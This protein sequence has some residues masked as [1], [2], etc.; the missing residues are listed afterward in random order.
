MFRIAFVLAV[1]SAAFAASG[2]RAQNGLAGSAPADS[3]DSHYTFSR[4]QDGYLRLDNRTGQVSFCNKRTVGWARQLVPE[5]RVA[6]EG[7][8][9]RLQ[10]ENATLK[11]EF[12]TRGLPLPG[13]IQGD[14]PP[15]QGERSLKPR[16]DANIERMRSLAE[17]LWQRLVD[18]IV[19]MQKDVLKKS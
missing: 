6:F 17:K 5:D 9:A 16:N 2:A 18:L 7:E 14:P 12:L 19:S 10:E 15:A 13:G 11:R 8:I 1:A 4:V 3:A